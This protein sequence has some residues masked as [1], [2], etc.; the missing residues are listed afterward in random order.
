M[1]TAN[2]AIRQSAII[3]ENNPLHVR[4]LVG[5]G[6]SGAMFSKR[7][8]K[9]QSAKRSV[10]YQ[11]VGSI[12]GGL[13]NKGDKTVFWSGLANVVNKAVLNNSV[14]SIQG[15][16]SEEF[17]GNPEIL[18]KSKDLAERLHSAMQPMLKRSGV[19]GIKTIET[20]AK[21]ITD[22]LYAQNLSAELKVSAFT[23]DT[24][25]VIHRFQNTIHKVNVD[26]LRAADKAYLSEQ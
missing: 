21:K 22:L 23:K 10:L 3:E 15:F 12:D 26:N 11:T 16:I 6:R 8:P 14:S 5:D 19:K 25:G 18:S 4:A 20:K 24:I 2:Q 13:K 17:S 9:S 7:V 1:I